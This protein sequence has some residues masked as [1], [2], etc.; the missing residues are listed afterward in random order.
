MSGAPANA[1]LKRT[2][3][4]LAAIQRGAASGSLIT[5]A[6]GGGVLVFDKGLLI[7]ALKEGEPKPSAGENPA[8]QDSGDLR[9]ASLQILRAASASDGEPAF[10]TSARTTA[11][12]I[13]A[14]LN[15]GDLILDLV[16]ASAEADWVRVEVGGGA[17]RIRHNADPPAILPGLALQPSQ[18]FLLSR[19]DGKMTLDEVLTVSPLGE[20]E[21][22]ATLYA[23][24]AAG[25]LSAESVD[26]LGHL[27]ALAPADPAPADVVRAGPS[28][29]VP[30]APAP[31][32]APETPPK[33]TASA[34]DDFLKRTTLP[35]AA[36]PAK[37]AG[38]ASPAGR[39]SSKAEIRIA[40]KRAELERR[41]AE[42]QGATHYAVLGV[43]RTADEHTIRRAYYRLAKLFH[44]DK[45]CLPQMEDL[46]PQIEMMFA[47]TTGAYN[48]LSDQAARAEYDRQTQE[49]GAGAKPADAD[50]PAQ[51]RDSYL[52]AR[53][54]LDSDELFDAL[55]LLET[56]ISLDPSKPDYWL[57]LGFVQT[58]NPRW[59]KR[60]E[61]T[62]LRA[63]EM[64]PSSVAAYQHL[65]RLYKSGGLTRRSQEMYE[66]LLQWDPDDKEALEELGRRPPDKKGVKK[67]EK[68][69]DDAGAAGRLRSLFKGSKS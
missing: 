56:A 53:K 21:T 52:R 6:Q 9:G 45:H 7:R 37:V 12:A 54:H 14:S 65:A 38:D 55:K 42:C 35:D 44:P 28:G 50:L 68:K 36:P 26:V 22:L 62:L 58:K 13:P 39:A 17:C 60:A 23:F 16:V 33:K 61:A 29:P 34:L 47:Q 19:A 64:N 4:L 2:V 8:G 10:I 46:L 67:G 15:A 57:Y 41:I 63:I 24:L 51:A 43:E 3:A 49:L 25:L 30:A 40:E 59:R 69:A 31:A 1:G 32:A 5:K 11:R 18:G 66:K 20:R 48:T 27:P